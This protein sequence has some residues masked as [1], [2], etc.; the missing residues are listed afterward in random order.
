M[1]RDRRHQSE[2]RDTPPSDGPSRTRWAIDDDAS[3]DHADRVALGLGGLYT[4]ERCRRCGAV[5]VTGPLD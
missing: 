5:V 3:C 2:A 1:E 4:Y